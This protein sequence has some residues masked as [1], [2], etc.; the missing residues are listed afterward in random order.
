MNGNLYKKLGFQMVGVTKPN[1]HYV[2]KGKRENRIN[3]QKHKLV[4]KGFDKNLTEVEI[5]VELGH[6]RIFNCGN[7]K[8][9]YKSNEKIEN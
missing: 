3:Y 7:E 5:M 1:Y 9:I 4:K 2:V 8:Y 6:Y